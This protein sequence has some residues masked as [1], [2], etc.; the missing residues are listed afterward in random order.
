MPNSQPDQDSPWKTILRQYF[1]E[2]ITFF[3]PKTAA[4]IDW[5]HPH[6]F[7][8][9]EFQQIAP[10]AAIGKRYADQLVKVWLKQGQQVWLL[11]HIE[12]QASPEKIF[13]KRILIY[14][15]RIFARFDSHPVS[16]AI[17]CDRSANWRPNQYSFSSPD[18]DLTFRFGIVKL[19]DY[20]ERWVDL[21]QSRNPFAVV[22]MA[23][24]KTQE[25]RKNLRQRKEWKFS[26]IRGLYEQG[27]GRQEVVNLFRFIDWVMILP[28]GLSREFWQELKTYEEERQMPYVSSVERIGFEEGHQKGLQQGLQQGREEGE[29]SLILR[30]LTRRVGE[31]PERVRS[32]IEA[33]S[34]S[35]LNLLG[36]SLLDFSG[37]PDLEAWLAS[38]AD[39]P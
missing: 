5:S 16:L 39:L 32:Q 22:V 12:I 27:Y 9:K 33:L 31:L 26:L 36:E 4:R 30:Q 21:E 3:F 37:L 28:E 8:D 34:I 14:H 6:E 35:Q 18:T 17:L 38:Q 7:L 19:L 29:R 10:D 11:L 24:L 25:T 1:Q 20:Q 23:H 15:L 13:P 2:A